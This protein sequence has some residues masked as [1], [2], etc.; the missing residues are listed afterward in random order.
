M[1]NDHVG[2]MIARIRNAQRA[3]HKFAIVTVAK[4][5]KRV[6]DVL[7]AE[8]FIDGYELVEDAEKRKAYKVGLKYF[9]SGKPVITKAVRFSKA[10]CRK[11]T[12]ADNLPKINSG[13]G[14]SII[15]TSKGV[16]SDH[17]ARKL[18][19]GGEIVAFF[20]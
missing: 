20:S 19:V 1:I 6:L 14:V 12:G 3:K 15:S 5:N 11:Y 16:M 2:D 8:G 17:Q 10:G 13:L 4:L 7:Q 18:R 9:S